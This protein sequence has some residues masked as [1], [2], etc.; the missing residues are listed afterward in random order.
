MELS[1]EQQLEAHVDSLRLHL[2]VTQ[3]PTAIILSVVLSVLLTIT[4]LIG[5]IDQMMLSTWIVLIIVVAILRVLLIRK[6]KNTLRQ[7]NMSLSP[8]QIKRYEAL[9]CL[10]AFLSGALLGGLG[11]F[12]DASWPLSTQFIIPFMLVGF[13]AAAV[14]SSSSSL[15]SYYCFVAPLLLPLSYGLYAIDIKFASALVVVYLVTMVFLSRRF[16]N[17]I[18]KNLRLQFDNEELINELTESNHNQAHLIA[19]KKEQQKKLEVMAHYD[20]LTQLPNRVLFAE[21][22]KQAVAHSKRTGTLLAIGFIDLDYF[23]PVNDTYGHA[24]GDQVLI[25]VAA[26]IKAAIREEDTL[27]RQGGDEFSFLV[28]DITHISK[29]GL[30]LDRILQV[31]SQPYLIEEQSIT[32]GAS[33]GYTIHPLDEADFDTLLR[34]ADHAMYQAKLSGRNT[35][36]LFDAIQDQLSS[37]QHSQLQSIH[38]ALK[39]NELCLYYQPKVNMK[40]GKV[41]GAEA[42]IRW[43]HPERGLVPPLKFLPIIEGTN[44][45]IEVGNWVLNEALQQLEEWRAQGIELEVSINISTYHLQSDSFHSDLEVA[46]ARHP[47]VDSQYLQLEILESSALGDVNSL[48]RT[49]KNCQVTLGINIALDD[50]GTGYSSLTHLRNLPANTIKIDQSFVRDVLDDPNDYSIIDGIIGLAESFNREVIAEGV[51]TSEHGLMLL[52]MGCDMAQGYGI[53]RPMPAVDI[54]AWLTDYTPNQ[55]W[56]ACDSNA[57]TLRENKKKLFRLT[58]DHWLNY[59]ETNIQSDPKEA[60]KWPMGTRK[61]THCGTWIKRAQNDQLFNETWLNNL[62]QLHE[63]M[64]RIADSLLIKYQSGEIDEARAGLQELHTAYESIIN[65]LN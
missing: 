33:I 38:N 53:A 62:E 54:P 52:T 63:R 26:R 16:N 27:S 43:Q 37:Q 57:L 49:I 11:L 6:I 13:S 35:Y 14:S 15:H 51:E 20:M 7:N 12:I 29:F 8:M 2:L 41:L 31:L 45:E 17:V 61:K 3:G 23:K 50:F 28:R 48:S 10:G 4:L 59:F 46:L 19:H 44:L 32:I 24:V 22:F 36:C 39:N 30:L 42:L 58:L 60:Q 18:V 55:E 56:M 9:Y 5:I 40:T 21:H 34:H 47:E 65:M 25:E 64:H 1:K